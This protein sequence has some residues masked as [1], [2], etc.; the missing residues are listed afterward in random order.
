[1]FKDFDPNGNRLLSL[2]ECQKGIRDVL[3]L[4]SLFECKPAIIRAFNYSKN[5][6]K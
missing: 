2:A 5:R 6:G 1:M 3:K 4:P